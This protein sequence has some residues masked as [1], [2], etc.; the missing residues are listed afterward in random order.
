MT[1][2]PGIPFQ[3]MKA[4][5][6]SE[7]TQRWIELDRRHCWHPFTPQSIWGEES[8]IL[9][10]ESGRGVWLTDSLGR[11]Y[12]DGNSSIW[13]N[14][15]GHSHPRIIAAMKAQLDKI[16]HSSFLGFSHG[17]ASELAAR[18]TAL[19]PPDTLTRVFFSDDGSTA[20]ESA[21]KLAFQA[22]IQTPGEENRRR[23]IAF[24]NCYHGDTMG[25]ASLGGVGA[26]FEKFR[27]FGV[28]V[29]HV[30]SAEELESLPAGECARAAGV[31]I[32]PVIQ[33]VNRMTP[34]PAGMLGRLRSWCD[35]NGV[36]LI[37]DEVMTGFG[38]TGRL[39]ACMHEGVWPDFLCCAKGLTNGCSPMAAVLTT[40]KI[41]SA[42]LGAPEEGRTFHYGHSFTAHPVGCAAAL[43]SLDL[44]EEERT[45]D[46]L[47]PKIALI[48]ELSERLRRENPCV[49]AVRH[50]GMIAGMDVCHADG[51]PFLPRERAG[52]RACAAMRPHGLLT[53]PV[54]HDTVVFMPPLCIDEEE[55]R[56]A[57]RALDAGIRSLAELP[58]PE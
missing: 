40:E 36:P 44:F 33:G 49:S 48:A 46:K 5:P 45:L 37:F 43:A 29:T 41:Y 56:L 7:R 30:S 2:R 26:F 13:V 54:V 6:P 55:I 42:F 28:E 24:S 15:H 1:P 38:R 39:F 16:A 20:L 27:G 32:E 11:R 12:I 34:W 53:R 35:A 22:H 52:E 47:P 19:F 25:A 21:L 4:P 57:F 8:E 18:L 50:T 58:R 23:F 9:M 31:V 51:S 17:P 14:I 3:E 10:I